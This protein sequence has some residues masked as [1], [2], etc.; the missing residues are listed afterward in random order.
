MVLMKSSI[1]VPAHNEEEHIEECLASLIN[2]TKKASEI[3]LVDDGSTDKT[4][5]LA[6][7]FQ[8]KI[9]KLKHN[10]RG[11]ARNTGWRAAK[12]DIIGWRA[13][14]EDIIFFAEADSICDKNWHKEMLKEFEK[15]AD[16]VIDRKAVYNPK[17]FF[18]K[19]YQANLNVRYSNYTPFNA[20]AFKKEVLQKVNGFDENLQYAGDREL[21]MR[22]M[23]EGFKIFFAK[24]AIQYHRGYP[25]NYFVFIKKMIIRGI[26]KGKNFHSKHPHTFP[27]KKMFFPFMLIALGF[28]SFIH[29]NFFYSL[30]LLIIFAYT[31]ALFK[32]AILEKG[33]GKMQ[34]QYLFGIALQK[35]VNLTFYPLAVFLGW[36]NIK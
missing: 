33:F 17:T 30:I 7:K 14:K 23:E 27:T 6:S 24:N 22:I 34:T 11:Y 25:K 5:E 28:L 32:I 16:A 2:Q 31:F 13:A 3:I 21:G 12:E 1:V 35:F 18:E 36:S 15:G 10:G 19:T 26:D 29:V 20:W 9:I 8:V 4:V